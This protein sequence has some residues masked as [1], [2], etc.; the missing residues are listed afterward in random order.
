MDRDE[1][2]FPEEM[3]FEA[4]LQEFANSVGFICGLETGGRVSAA[5]AYERIRALW[6]QLKASRK[7]LRIN[8]AD[9]DTND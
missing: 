8:G 4:N 7:N 5:E 1:P 6:K 3:V 2:T 9:P